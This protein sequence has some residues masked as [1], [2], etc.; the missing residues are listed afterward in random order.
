MVS[1]NRSSK[2]FTKIFFPEGLSKQ[3]FNLLSKWRSCYSLLFS[4]LNITLS[5]KIGLKISEISNESE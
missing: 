2:A 3:R 1:F 4:N 5:T